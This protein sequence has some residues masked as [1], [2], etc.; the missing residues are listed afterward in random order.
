MVNPGTTKPFDNVIRFNV[1]Q[2]LNTIQVWRI[3]VKDQH[4]NSVSF[5]FCWIGWFFTY[6]PWI[7]VEFFYSSHFCINFSWIC[8]LILITMSSL[9]K[10]YTIRRHKLCNAIHQYS[11][12]LC[13]PTICYY[14]YYTIT[15]FILHIQGDYNIIM[16][17]I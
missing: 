3:T 16:G 1:M 7:S 13:F 17:D 9:N 12:M 10:F 11:T 4:G 5:N 14:K 2:W 8:R 15:T 6:F